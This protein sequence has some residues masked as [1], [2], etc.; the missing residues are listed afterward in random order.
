ME[1][2]ALWEDFSPLSIEAKLADHE[3][4]HPS[5][6]S[7]PYQT[8]NSDWANLKFKL[9]K[10]SSPIPSPTPSIIMQSPIHTGMVMTPFSSANLPP[11]PVGSSGKV[12]SPPGQL[13]VKQEMDLNM[14][15]S[16]GAFPHQYNP[17]SYTSQPSNQAPTSTYL[18]TT[19]PNISSRPY[20]PNSPPPPRVYKPCFVCQDKSSGY[21]YGVSACEGC[22]GFFRRSVQKAMK[23]TCHRDK[24]C[25]INKITRNRCQYCRF[26]KCFAVGMSKDCVR[27]DRNKKKKDTEVTQSVTIPNEIEEV[28][29]SVTKAHDDTFLAEPQSSAFPV[30]EAQCSSSSADKSKDSPVDGCSLDRTIDSISEDFLQYLWSSPD[31]TSPVEPQADPVTQTDTQMLDCVTTV[32]TRAIVMVVDFAKKLPGFLSLT[33]SDQITLLKAACLEILTLRI[34]SKFN[35]GEGE[36]GAVTFS[37]GMTL[38][39]TQLKTGGFGSLMDDIVKLSQSFKKLKIDHAEMALL[40]AVCLISGDR[41]GLENPKKVEKMQEPYLE[42]LRLYVHKRRPKESN[43]FAKILMK[44]TDVRHISVMSAER[45]MKL[46]V[47]LPGEIPALIDEMVDRLDDE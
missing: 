46:K 13:S 41:T 26:Q 21:H 10:L 4:P 2:N 15:L 8:A 40:A 28:I 6:V 18:H 34:S 3:N 39:K 17:Y 19:V 1:F 11:S 27:N 35:K 16:P 30:P 31:F 42:G 38:N 25:E 24:Q 43:A 33:T 29:K 9:E 12:D 20:S 22:K 44:I 45:V 37:S 36:G 14:N 7:S 47:D 32:S 23:Y 5:P